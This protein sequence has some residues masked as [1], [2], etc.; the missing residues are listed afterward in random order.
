M[1]R[2]HQPVAVELPVLVAE[3]TKPAPGVVVPLVGKAHGDAIVL[4]GPQLLDQSVVE[5]AVPL[6]TEKRHDLLS[7]DD[8]LGPVAPAALHAVGERD[9]LGVARI[10][11]VLGRAHLLDR[12]VE[13]ERWQ[14]G[15]GLGALGRAIGEPRHTMS[16]QAPTTMPAGAPLQRQLLTPCWD[17]RRA[18]L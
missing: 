16:S 13:R 12:C 7:A 1:T 2:D 10:P 15:P 3:R 18:A 11:A 9:T 4:K 14:W 8:E 6:A 5:L 17:A